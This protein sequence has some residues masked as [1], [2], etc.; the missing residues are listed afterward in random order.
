MQL[1]RVGRLE[2]R[3]PRAPQVKEISDL[4]SIEDRVV[5]LESTCREQKRGAETLL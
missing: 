4:I 2:G 3:A 5:E 1:N